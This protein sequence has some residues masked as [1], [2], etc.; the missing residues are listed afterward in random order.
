MNTVACYRV[1]YHKPDRFLSVM[2]A[3]YDKS[4]QETEEGQIDAWIKKQV[5]R[6]IKKSLSSFIVSLCRFQ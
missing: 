6:D 4:G 2:S 5:P 3:T 1:F